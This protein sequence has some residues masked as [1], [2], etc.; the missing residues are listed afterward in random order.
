MARIWTAPALVLRK[1]V[2]ADY[3]VALVV[4]LAPN[5]RSIN[6]QGPARHVARVA[7]NINTNV[8]EPVRPTSDRCRYDTSSMTKREAMKFLREASEELGIDYFD[9]TYVHLCGYPS[10]YLTEVTKT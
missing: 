5:G 1:R 8:I 6:F 2:R 10:G 7:R 9:K 3:D 4:F